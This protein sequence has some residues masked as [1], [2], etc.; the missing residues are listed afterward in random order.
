MNKINCFIS[1]SIPGL[2]DE[3]LAELRANTKVNRVYLL[4]T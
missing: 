4:G 2:W 1:Y 3:T